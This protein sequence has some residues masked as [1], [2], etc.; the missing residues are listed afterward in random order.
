MIE[1]IENKECS[2][3]TGNSIS[4]IESINRIDENI[5]YAMNIINRNSFNYISKQIGTN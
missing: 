3:Q 4:L 1:L 5:Y 2:F